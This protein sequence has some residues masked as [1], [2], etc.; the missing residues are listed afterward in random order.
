[1]TGSRHARRFRFATIALVAVA[2]LA[3]PAA[4]LAARAWT[5]SASPTTLPAGAAG[6]V[7]LTVQNVG[8]SSGGDELTCVQVSVPSV[9]AVGSG[10]IVSVRGVTSPAMH[11]WVVVTG[12]A[13][14]RT[15]VTFK[16]PSDKNPLVGLPVGDSAVF[17]ISGTAAA[18]G[19]MTWTAVAADK[20]GGSTSTSC[21]SGTFPTISLAFTVG[22]SP[23][24]A[25]TPKPTARP[26]A[27]PVPT[28]APT[29]TP[30]PRPTSAPTVTPRPTA[31][32]TGP[33][34]PTPVPSQPPSR[35]VLPSPTTSS[36]P[37]FEPGSSLVPSGAPSTGG[38]LDG[39]IAGPTP[40][41]GGGSTAGSADVGSR[42][43][44]GGPST[45]QLSIP[46]APAAHDDGEG[47]AGL[48]A[49]LGSA[50]L[51]IGLLGWTVPMVALSVPGLLLILVI[52]LQVVGGA[53]W[54]PLTRRILSRAD[55]PTGTANS[56]RRDPGRRPGR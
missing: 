41:A 35:S 19:S 32:S 27:T 47:I 34:F 51:D 29:P 40:P 54:L 49:T 55:S 11:G 9:F 25:P 18:S 20:P 46:F 38:P 30:S 31:T 28:P 43:P 4:V 23:T 17:R 12:S 1:L 37:S 53:A 13:A 56:K 22:S 36:G 16:N 7:T 15:L 10:T 33:G 50:L 48:D 42:R 24:P 39:G 14:G 8:S 21:G 44:P 26:T 5:L 3:S 52:G 45:G 6:T 2:A